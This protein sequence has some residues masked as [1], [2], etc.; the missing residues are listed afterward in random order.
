MKR[1]LIL[2]VFLVSGLW[3][4]LAMA[5]ALLE[6]SDPAPGAVLKIAPATVT[7]F[8]DA[9][10]EPVFSKMVVKNKQGEKVSEGNGETTGGPKTLSARLVTK[11]PGVYHVYWDVV[12]RDGHRAAGDF[13]FTVQ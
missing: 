6:R 7:V 5:H 3:C 11:A 10:L 9:E 2:C 12:S 8:F 4:D 1:L 13:T